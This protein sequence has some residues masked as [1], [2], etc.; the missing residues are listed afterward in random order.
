MLRHVGRHFSDNGYDRVKWKEGETRFAIRIG[1]VPLISSI[2][3]RH[4]SLPPSNTM[5]RSLLLILC[6]ASTSLFANESEPND[7][8]ATADLLPLDGT[9]CNATLE[10]RSDV[11]GSAFQMPS[12]GYVDITLGQSTGSGSNLVQIA[13][14]LQAADDLTTLIDVVALN[15]RTASSTIRVGLPRNGPDGSVRTYLLQ[16][17]VA[18]FGNVQAYSLSATFVA[19]ATYEHEPNNIPDSAQTIVLG[20]TYQGST[21]RSDDQDWFRFQI[22]EDSDLSIS[23]SKDSRTDQIGPAH[24]FS[25]FST[26]SPSTP[27][28][29]GVLRINDL[30]AAFIEGL[31]AQDDSGSPVDY[32]LVIVPDSGTPDS[33]YNLTLDA[34]PGRF[35]E[36]SPNESLS[37]ANELRSTA[38]ELHLGR[39]APRT[40]QDYYQFQLEESGEVEIS[41]SKEQLIDSSLSRFE[42]E[43]FAERDLS[44]PLARILLAGDESERS[45]T[46]DLSSLVPGTSRSEIYY[47]VVGQGS[48]YS[49]DLVDYR[50]SVTAPG[51][52]RL[53]AINDVSLDRARNMLNIAFDSTPGTVYTIESSDDLK[54]WD[55]VNTVT[56]QGSRTATE[57][58]V[59]GERI[60]FRISE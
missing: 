32:F 6:A 25:L 22:G 56:S 14:L 59:S 41:I 55:V 16:V 15:G 46:L 33:T 29:Q 13:G 45:I 53:L 49:S 39:I 1:A 11:D 54:D 10:P 17:A 60:Y 18:Q 47:L 48:A 7:T 31:P 23:L 9:I 40:D 20:E 8:P 19:D 34:T 3:L 27:I 12:D 43:V 30:Q 51:S 52:G 35:F 42:L 37:T 21:S 36:R 58:S 38:G 5:F 26:L 24:E 50:V 57:V 4:Y 44:N 28:R 2:E